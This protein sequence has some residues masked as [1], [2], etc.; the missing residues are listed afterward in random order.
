[1]GHRAY[2]IKKYEIEY[3]NCL[4][5]NY[6]YEGCINFL[7][8]FGLETYIDE[9]ESYIEVSSQ[10]LIDLNIKE[11]KASDE[12]KVRLMALKRVALESDYAKNGYVRIEWL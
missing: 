7:Q 6:D 1:M 3:G 9:S 8:S 11:L 5:F 4:G 10:S 12:N 2:T